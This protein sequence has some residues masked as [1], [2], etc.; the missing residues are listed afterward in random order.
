MFSHCKHGSS[1]Q[2]KSSSFEARAQDTNHTATCLTLPDRSMSQ[3]NPAATNLACTDSAYSLYFLF[4]AIT[5]SWRGDSHS[6]H[7]PS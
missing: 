5:I 7:L 2:K 6:G 3:K 4:T 1:Q